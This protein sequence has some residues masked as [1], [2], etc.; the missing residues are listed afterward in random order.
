MERIS[1][2]QACR[3]S[4]NED[5]EFQVGQLLRVREVGECNCNSGS[6]RVGN[7]RNESGESLVRSVSKIDLTPL[8]ILIDSDSGIV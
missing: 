3:R 2:W 6:L 4:R 1:S 5:F 8:I 7:S